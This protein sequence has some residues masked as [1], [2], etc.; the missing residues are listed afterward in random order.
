MRIRLGMSYKAGDI[1]LVKFPSA[2]LKKSKKRP[3]VVVKSENELKDIVCF[4]ITSNHKQTNLLKIENDDLDN[5]TLALKSFI[6]YDK[7]FTI[8]TDIVDKKIAKI[9]SKLLL[10]LKTLFCSELF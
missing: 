7:C 4:Q 5:S 6:K 3:V 10:Q 2:D 8:N 1:A 9:N